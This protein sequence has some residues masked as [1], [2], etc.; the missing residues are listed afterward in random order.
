MSD[1]RLDALLKQLNSG[2][3]EAAEKLLLAHEP[4]LRMVV[5]RLLT[6][7]LRA[8]FDTADIV[9]SVWADVLH[10]CPEAGWHFTD[11]VSLRAF[12]IKAARNRF[13]DRLRQVRRALEHERPLTEED[14]K[15]GPPSPQPRPSEVAQ[16][17]DLWEEMLA[18]CPPTH[19][20]LLRLKRQGLPLA[21]IAARTGL[22][23]SSIR[24]ILYGLAQ[25]LAARKAP[26]SDEGAGP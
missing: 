15:D 6:G 19:R 24:R 11:V 8:K 21:E 18:L 22:H 12:L 25:R 7:Q 16:A 2:N 20:E 23:E 9:Q 26:S 4:Y 1:D 3:T 5:H 13:I 10:H 14:L 17:E